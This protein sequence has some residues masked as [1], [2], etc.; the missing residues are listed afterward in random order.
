MRSDIVR[1]IAAIVSEDYILIEEDPERIP[2]PF[3]SVLIKERIEMILPSGN[4]LV[5][6]YGPD[7]ISFT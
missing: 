1:T 4:R 7:D 6:E 5:P 2:G 3:L